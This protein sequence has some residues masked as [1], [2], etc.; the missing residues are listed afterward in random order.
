MPKG[1]RSDLLRLLQR[2]H[3]KPFTDHKIFENNGGVLKVLADTTHELTARSAE[4]YEL[5]NDRNT[6]PAQSSEEWRATTGVYQTVALQRYDRKEYLGSEHI[7]ALWNIGFDDI[8]HDRAIFE[9]NSPWVL[10]QDAMGGFN[11]N[12]RALLSDHKPK[13]LFLI[14]HLDLDDR[15]P[16]GSNQYNA[17]HFMLVIFS[18]IN[19][20]TYVFDTI[21]DRAQERG[22]RA[23][24]RLGMSIAEFEGKEYDPSKIASAKV[25]TFFKQQ[26]GWSCGYWTAVIALMILKSPSSLWSDASILMRGEELDGNRLHEYM[27]TTVPWYIG[28]MIGSEERLDRSLSTPPQIGYWDVDDDEEMTDLEPMM[29]GALPQSIEEEQNSEVPV[30]DSGA[31]DHPSSVTTEEVEGRD[32]LQEEL[33]PEV[34]ELSPEEEE[35]AAIANIFDLGRRNI[36]GRHY[37]IEITTPYRWVGD[38]YD[39]LMQRPMPPFPAQ[40]GGWDDFDRRVSDL[41]FERRIELTVENENR[42]ARYRRRLQAREARVRR[43]EMED[44][45]SGSLY[46]E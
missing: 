2:L 30:S 32:M 34:S 7:R 17:P 46:G 14:Q 5:L 4:S 45:E 21:E 1:E 10:K 15:S 11:Y 25:F 24:A 6:P 36:R 8:S 9:Q 23:A 29:T 12:T 44:E 31:S 3:G 27:T 28:V 20:T 26:D 41:R 40:W 19:R 13:H 18:F 38:T 35:A 43:G 16:Q 37:M 42:R 22:D 39:D 33:S